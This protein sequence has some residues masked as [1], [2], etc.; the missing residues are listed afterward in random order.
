MVDVSPF[1][2]ASTPRERFIMRSCVGANF[3]VVLCCILYLLR[4]YPDLGFWWPYLFPA[5][6][7]AYFLAD[8]ASGLVHWGIDTWF[9]TE[10]LGRAV[11][12]ARE[13]HTH[14]QNILG[15]SFVEHSALGSAPS[16]VFIGLPALCIVAFP[17]CVVTYCAMMIF[18]VSS[19]CLLFGTSF[20]NLGHRKPTSGILRAA[21]RLRLVITPEHHWVHHRNGQLRHYCAV[22]GWANYLCDRLE[23]WRRLERAITRI[24][25]AVPRQDDHVWQDHFRNTGTLLPVAPQ[26]DHA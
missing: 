20:H 5:L 15:Y 10:T 1:F 21:Q 7:L 19:A 12:I 13:H 3:V 9:A 8:I 24:T 4:H 17:V 14:P 11:A 6:L 18:M 23:F 26:Q 2:A 16:A 22:N 25:G